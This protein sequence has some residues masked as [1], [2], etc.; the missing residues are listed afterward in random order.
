M[1]TITQPT[2]VQ[3]SEILAWLEREEAETGEGFLCNKDIIV[4]AFACEEIYCAVLERSVVGFVT[5]NVKSQS[6][7]IDILEVCPAH[8]RRGYGTKLALDAIERLFK[9]GAPNITVKCAP[10]SS[11]SFWRKFGFVTFKPRQ[12]IVPLQLKLGKEA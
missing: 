12:G 6:A 2:Q 3:L 10:S 11:E 5:H 1:L 9:A 7:S 8:R 4:E